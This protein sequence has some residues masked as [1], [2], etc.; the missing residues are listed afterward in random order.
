MFGGRGFRITGING[1]TTQPFTTVTIIQNFEKSR[2][3]E[4]LVN[5]LKEWVLPPKIFR[6]FL[7]CAI[8]L[9]R[10]I[11][12]PLKDRKILDRNSIFIDKYKGRRCFVIGN[13]PSLNKVDLSPL[14]NE[15][16]IVM[17]NFEHH[18]ILEKWQPTIHCAGDGPYTF[19]HTH[20]EELE[21]IK[22]SYKK[23]KPEGFFVPLSMKS[24]IETNNMI[25]KDKVYYLDMNVDLSLF[26][27]ITNRDIDLTK[28][29]PSV[30]NT[31]LLAIILAM[32]IGCKKIYILGLDSDWS[33]L[34][35]PLNIRTYHFYHE[36]NTDIEI[37]PN[38]LR[39]Y[40]IGIF[41][42]TTLPIFKCHKKLYEYAR[43][44]NIEI[45]NVTDGSYLD[46][47]PQA[48]FEDIL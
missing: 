29:M 27:E 41:E 36:F 15:I 28:R 43:K 46:E 5:Y 32:A 40:Y 9:Y 39:G 13:G 26:E 19:T 10:L 42:R 2:F 33:A 45:I 6:F 37:D 7:R 21:K 35:T 31:A 34:A 14:K 3:F 12:P 17:N 48:K 22:I 4:I 38:S 44:N 25:P 8:N 20:P 47:Y 18:P 16:T 11:P 30:Y 1:E 23:I 24:L